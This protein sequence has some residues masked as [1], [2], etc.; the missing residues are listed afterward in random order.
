LTLTPLMC[1][2]VLKGRGKGSKKTWLER[3][4]GGIEH[5]VLDSYGRS[6]WFFLRHRWVS[7]IVWVV[8]LGGTIFLFGSASQGVSP[9]G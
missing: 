1:A 7:A 9:G 2:R 8:C 5:R 6:L 4:I 3:V